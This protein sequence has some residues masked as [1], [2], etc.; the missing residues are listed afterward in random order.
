MYMYEAEKTVAI[1]QILD[2]LATTHWYLNLILGMFGNLS[3]L[4]CAPTYNLVPKSNRTGSTGQ[5]AFREV[6]TWL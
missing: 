4:V 1:N 2:Y 5:K 6:F 3:C